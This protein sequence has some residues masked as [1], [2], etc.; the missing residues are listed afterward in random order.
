MDD[1]TTWPR[2]KQFEHVKK[3]LK[4]SYEEFKAENPCP[5]A[6]IVDVWDYWAP[7]LVKEVERLNAVAEAA[8]R[9]VENWDKTKEINHERGVYIDF[10]LP[11]PLDPNFRPKS[12]LGLAETL[13]AL[14]IEDSNDQET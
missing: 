13:R 11:H 4:H 1:F 10:S 2:A 12:E 8:K 14:T 3:Q 9:H 7:W 5:L 6:D